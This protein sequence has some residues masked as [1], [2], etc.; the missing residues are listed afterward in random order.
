M[1]INH[2]KQNNLRLGFN[3]TT[4]DQVCNPLEYVRHL[5]HHS[6]PLLHQGEQLL[7]LFRGGALLVGGDVIV[8]LQG[9]LIALHSDGVL[10][11]TVP[12]VGDPHPGLAHLPSLEISLFEL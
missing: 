9:L 1:P 11:P 5:S 2:H 10:F 4:L 12:P 6:Q 8:E 3:L 7:V